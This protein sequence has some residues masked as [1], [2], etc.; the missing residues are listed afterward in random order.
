MDVPWLLRVPPR[1]LVPGRV[2]V[3]AAVAA[4]G[5]TLG[6][7]I[8][9]AIPDLMIKELLQAAPQRAWMAGCTALLSG[10]LAAIATRAKT[11]G[12]ALALCLL[13]VPAAVL[14]TMLGFMGV[15]VLSNGVSLRGLVFLAELGAL[16]G[17]FLGGPCGVALGLAYAWPIVTFV[18]ARNE[19]SLD[20][21][22]RVLSWTGGW[23]MIMGF[24]AVVLGLLRR[25]ID[26]ALIADAALF[27]L[28]ALAFARGVAR[29]MLRGR[30]L[31]EVRRGCI[32]EFR[33]VPREPAAWDAEGALPFG[34]DPPETCDALL[35]HVRR[36]DSAYR[37]AWAHRVYALVRAS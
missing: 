32:P 12:G 19:A 26:V 4:T 8:V 34:A 37:D 22:D 28:G 5:A 2:F 10:I 21:L 11:L 17:V 29:R 18:R 35:V 36:A 24:G 23:A 14:N 13:A 30:W 25:E 6:F 1:R 16:L 33:V 3:V 27:G 20:A 31:R 7:E 15:E 9:R